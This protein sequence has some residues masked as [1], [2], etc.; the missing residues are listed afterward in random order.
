MLNEEQIKLIERWI[1][2]NVTERVVPLDEGNP[3]ALIYNLVALLREGKG[4]V[5]YDYTPEQNDAL[6]ELERRY[7]CAKERYL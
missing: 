7:G 5:E 4:F 2:C 1:V 6:H 3:D